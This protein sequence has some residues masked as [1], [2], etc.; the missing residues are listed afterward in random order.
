[1]RIALASLLLIAPLCGCDAVNKAVNKPN[2]MRSPIGDLI[3]CRDQFQTAMNVASR[4]WQDSNTSDSDRLRAILGFVK[5]RQEC[6]EKVLAKLK[7][8]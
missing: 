5:D 4:V 1:M 8:R 3:Q 7:R 2:K 6:E